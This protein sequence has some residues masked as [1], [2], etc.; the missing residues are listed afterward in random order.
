M[1]APTWQA[2]AALVA[3][4]RADLQAEHNPLAALGR[5]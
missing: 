3:T 2:S 1:Q 4:E 5:V